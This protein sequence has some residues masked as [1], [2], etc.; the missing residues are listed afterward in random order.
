[1]QFKCPKCD[2]QYDNVVSLSKHWS[3]THKEETKTLYMHINNL[4]VPPT[5]SCGCGQEVKFLDAGRGFSEYVWGHK[6][7]VSNNFNTEKSKSNSLQARKKML[8]EG[9]WK[10]F[11]EKETGEHWSK[12]KTAESDA[13]VAKSRD[14]IINNPEEIQR[15]SERM[16]ENRM[17]G[18]V[19]TLTGEKHSQWKGG[20]SSLN[21]TCRANPK[22]YKDWIY[23]ILKANDFKC[24]LCAS[25]KNLEV[26][27]DKETFSEIY[28]NI[29]KSY[30][31][32]LKLTQSLSSETDPEIHML[33]MLISDAVAQYHID[34]N[35]SGKVLCD[36]CHKEQH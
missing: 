21:H 6:A 13:R 8:Q 25:T 35:V 34:N 30:N 22:L 10:P 29:A 9:T 24:N 11:H 3:R 15:R 18:T 20:I 28:S 1:M 27:H 31:Y 7:R 5:C 2:K 14:S 33:K 26:H 36:L 12:G 32:P 17:N 23:P 19:P 4:T 16:K